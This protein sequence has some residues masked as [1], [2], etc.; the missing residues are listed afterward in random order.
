MM[1]ALLFHRLEIL[2][3]LI[4]EDSRPFGGIQL[5]ICGDFLQLPPVEDRV[6]I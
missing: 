3:R 1:H 2:A 6:G 4:R 5:V